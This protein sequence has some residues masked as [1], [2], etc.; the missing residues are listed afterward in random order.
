[1]PL[2]FPKP[3]TRREERTRRKSAS[4]VER[5]MCRRI[6][7]QRDHYRCRACA[8]YGGS[9]LDVHEIVPR[10]RGGS[11]YDPENCIALCRLCH[12]AVTVHEMTLTV[13]RDVHGLIWTFTRGDRRWS[14]VAT[15]KGA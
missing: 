13:E 15:S 3:P 9:S 6:V 2:R 8:L 14:T 7:L 10:S 12:R 1:M 4:R 5:E 11:P